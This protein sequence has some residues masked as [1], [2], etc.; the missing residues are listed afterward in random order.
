ML[1]SKMLKQ[2][3]Q[4]L[5]PVRPAV[6]QYVDNVI[7]AQLEIIYRAYLIEN[8]RYDN[9]EELRQF[10]ELLKSTSECLYQASDFTIKSHWF[11]YRYVR[12]FRY[13]GIMSSLKR[14]LFFAYVSLAANR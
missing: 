7:L 5:D 3:D 6:Q 8:R 2:Y 10:D 1:I 13:P 14:K 12:N 4:L 11:T 9:P